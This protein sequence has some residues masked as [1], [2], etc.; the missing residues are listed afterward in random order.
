M[1]LDP[2]ELEEL[3]KAL[4]VRAL[5]LLPRDIKAGFDELIRRAHGAGAT[6]VLATHDPHLLEAMPGRK[7]G[8]R[9]GR[10]VDGEAPHVEAPAV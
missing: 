5:K 8:L 6:V 1:Q 3:S 2:A 7:I 9:A 10:V 4:Y